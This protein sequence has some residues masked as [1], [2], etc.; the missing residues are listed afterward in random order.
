MGTLGEVA[1]WLS[2]TMAHARA[3]VARRYRRF[4]ARVMRRDSLLAGSERRFRA[5]LEAAPDT[6][7]IVDGHGHVTLVNAQAE[8]L[9]GYDRADL[10]GR[11]IGELI[12]DRFRTRHHS[13]VRGYLR[14]AEARPMGQR[15]ELAAR[16]RDGSEFPVE[17]SLGPLETDQGP[18]VSAAIRDITERKHAEDQLR[19]IA[20]HDALTGLWNRRRF[21]EQLGR[22]LDDGRRHGMQGALLLLDID[23]LK[24]V[25]DTLGHARGDELIGLVGQ[26]LRARMR[27]S[28]VVARLGGD[29]FAV[30]LTRTDPEP[31]LGIGRDLLELIRT[32]VVVL[33]GQRLRVTSTVGIAAFGAEPNTPEEV[34]IAADAALY[35]AK[36]A[37]RDRVAMYA[38]NA[39]EVIERQA[40]ASWTQRLR[41]ALDEER[42]LV[43]A[44]PIA[45]LSTRAIVRCELLMRLP[46]ADGRPIAPKAFLPTAERTGLIVDIDLYMITRAIELLGRV[47]ASALATAQVNVSG[48]SIADEALPRTVAALLTESSIDPSRLVFEITETTAISTME[49]VRGFARA[50]RSVGCG[51]ALDDFG[52]GFASFYYLKHLP[53]D[54][55]KIDRDFV[56]NLPSSRTDQLVVKHVVEIAAAL[57]LQT[58]AE[59]VE[60][61][62]TLDMLIERGVDMAQGFHIGPPA[63]LV[64]DLPEWTVPGSLAGGLGEPG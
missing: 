49:R 17:I 37:G 1:R 62:T 28:D 34:L 20:D 48:R 19:H 40:R 54:T 8:R 12:P 21:E 56:R 32:R 44:Q 39:A 60:D 43:Y 33:G 3:W 23:C 41:G 30:L 35:E 63:P 24:D 10:I 16:R 18:L 29:E 59:G 58:I 47:P 31:A 7:V 22:E 25:N 55:L 14:H 26:L 42:F 38:P 36:E 61:Q 51:F 2:I 64:T 46:D 45:D 15:L 52:A 53:V 6:M 4:A 50:L 9:F 57:G 11:G 27:S 13:H 5:L